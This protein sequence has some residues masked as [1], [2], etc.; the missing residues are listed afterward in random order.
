M[1]SPDGVI[2][3][4]FGGDGVGRTVASKHIEGQA[5]V[6]E[7]GVGYLQLGCLGGCFSSQ[8]WG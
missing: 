5:C 4:P 8:L 3:V 1:R 2:A 6:Q 7:I